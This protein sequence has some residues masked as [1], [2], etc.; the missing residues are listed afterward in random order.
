[1]SFKLYILRQSKTMQCLPFYVQLSPLL[2]VNIT[3]DTDGL[4]EASGRG[5][6][7]GSGPSPGVSADNGG[8]G[9]SHGGLGGRGTATEYAMPA[10]DNTRNPSDFG[11]GG[12]LVSW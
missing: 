1:M 11:S 7:A 12:S 6:K 8:S 3:V 5:W 9:G 2:A 4:I 10:Y